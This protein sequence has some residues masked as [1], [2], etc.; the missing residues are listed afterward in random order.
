MN[1][2][3]KEIN[4]L[5]KEH[6]QLQKEGQKIYARVMELHKKCLAIQQQLIDAEGEDYD[7]IPLIFG[8]G[9]WID[10]DL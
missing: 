7:P 5:K 3:P 4:N 10:P 9:F 8:D 1:M 2:T 6:N